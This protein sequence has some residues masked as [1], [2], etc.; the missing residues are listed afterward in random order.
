MQ[1]LQGMS[2]FPI[3]EDAVVAKST[4]LPEGEEKS[5]NLYLSGGFL[6]HII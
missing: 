2:Q 3:F 5:L 6:C 4:M 1:N